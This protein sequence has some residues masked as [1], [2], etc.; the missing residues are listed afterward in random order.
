M[1]IVIYNMLG[2]KVKT[3]VNKH[4]E[5]G[6]YEVNWNSTNDRGTPVG[7]GIYFYVVR[8]GKQHAVKKMALVK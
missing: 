4:Q 2:Q 5:A 1:K 7:S 3:L 8:A 6:Y